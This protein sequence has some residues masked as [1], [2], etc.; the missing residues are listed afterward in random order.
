MLIFVNSL[1][2]PQ[3]FHP[4]DVQSSRNTYSSHSE[5]RFMSEGKIWLSE[6]WIVNLSRLMRSLSFFW[7]FFEALFFWTWTSCSFFFFGRRFNIDFASDSCYESFEFNFATISCA[8][9]LEKVWTAYTSSTPAR[10]RHS[11][12]RRWPCPS[13]ELAIMFRVISMDNLRC[14]RT[15]LG[16]FVLTG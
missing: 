12:A 6:D 2:T 7:Q 16:C 13:P 1:M 3:S 8:Q 5:I 10:D 14:G 15:W 11:A 4:S 9:A